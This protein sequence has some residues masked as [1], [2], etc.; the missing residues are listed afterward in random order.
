MNFNKLFKKKKEVIFD[1][2]KSRKKPGIFPLSLE[3]TFQKTI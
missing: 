2:L 3:N 1:D